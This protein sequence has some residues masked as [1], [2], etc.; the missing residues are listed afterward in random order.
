ME[1]NGDE[2]VL[3]AACLCFPSSWSLDEKIGKPLIKIHEP[4]PSYD[5]Q[6]AKRVQRLFDAIR[7]DRPMYRVNTL[8]YSDPNLHQ[9]RTMSARRKV[10]KTSKLWL[11][12]EFQSLIRLPITKAVIFCIHNTIVPVESLT[13]QQQ[14][15]LK[16]EDLMSAYGVES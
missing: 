7:V 6:I 13:N 8:I 3:S 2:H 14:E 10:L 11:R 15:Q 4:V 5:D 1:E 12:S 16:F 9:P